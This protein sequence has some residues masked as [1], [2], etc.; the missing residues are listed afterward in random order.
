[1]YHFQLVSDVHLEFGEYKKIQKCANYLILAGDIGYP[2]QKLFKNFLVDVGEIFEK[3]FYVS[4]NHE[5]YQNWKKGKNIKIDT[6]DETNLKIKKIIE[7]CHDNIYFLN[8][9]YYDIDDKLRIVGSTLWTNIQPKSSSINDSNQIYS[10]NGILVTDDYLRNLHTKNVDFI[11][12]QISYANT[13]NKKLVIVTH[14]LPSYDLILEKYKL[15]YPRYTSH[16]AT[17]LNYLIKEPIKVWCAGHSHGFNHQKINEVDCYVNAFGYPS[18]NRQG[19]NLNFNFE[20][21]I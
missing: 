4:G 1:M 12:N 18:E 8:N 7:E 10:D 3:V 13:N 14:H 2:D 21:D 15:M 11:E 19:A 20:F 16:F 17:D 5:Y 6:I 9:D